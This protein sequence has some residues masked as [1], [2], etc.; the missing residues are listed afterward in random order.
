MICLLSRNA[1]VG[2]SPGRESGVLRQTKSESPEGTTGDQPK[3]LSSLW[4]FWLKLKTNP[5]LASEAIPC[6]R[7]AIRVRSTT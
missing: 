6:H 2:I 7:F 5:G 3:H 1:T 4:D